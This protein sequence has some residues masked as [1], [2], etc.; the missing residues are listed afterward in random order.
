MEFGRYC[1]RMAGARIVIVNFNAG[2]NLS[3]CM[4]ALRAQSMTDFEVKVVDNSSTDGSLQYVPDDGRFSIVRA[5]DNVGFA[6]ACNLGARNCAAPFVIF[7][8]P[9]AF[10]EPNWLQ[11]LL[12]AAAKY[13]DAAMFGSLQLS[14][15]DGNILDGAGDCYSY[16]GIPWRGGHG[17]PL[18]P[19]PDYAETFS[20]C[21]AAAMYQTEW[22][23]RVGGFDEAFFCYLEDVDLAFRVR[24]RG[25]RCL[26]VNSAVVRHV[27]GATSGSQSDF[28]IYHSARNRIWTIIKNVPGWLLCLVMPLHMA[29]T[30]YWYFRSRGFSRA[31]AIKQ[32]VRDA[33]ADL[34]RVWKQRIKIQAARTASVGSIARAMNWSPRALRKTEIAL[35]EW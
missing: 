8:N 17:Q 25:G 14:A 18:R 30:G 11:A 28:T 23:G 10:P 22:F 33:F 12:N 4:G 21:A 31:P 34:P 15:D 26:L 27:G 19:L 32:G 13:P 20:P 29:I 24:L 5:G 35:R 16:F 9:D 6:A 3:R 2:E 7:L 1:S